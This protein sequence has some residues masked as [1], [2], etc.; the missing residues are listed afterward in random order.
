MVYNRGVQADWDGLAAASGN[1]AWGWD[2]IVPHYTAMEDNQFG[3]SPTRG[4]GGPLGISS[5]DDPQ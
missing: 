5:G 3:A 1:P 2:E 4:V